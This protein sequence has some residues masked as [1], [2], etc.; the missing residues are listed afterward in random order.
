MPATTEQ[1]RRIEAYRRQV[2]EPLFAALRAH[3]W[4]GNDV[5]RHLGLHRQHIYCIRRGQI[6]MTR[7][8]ADDLCRIAG[9]PRE[10]IADAVL[11]QTIDE[12]AAAAAAAAAT[13]T[14]VTSDTTPAATETTT[15]T[16]TTRRRRGTH[17]QPDHTTTGTI[18]NVSSSDSGTER[19][20]NNRR[21]RVAAT[22]AA[23]GA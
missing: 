14:T 15:A 1:G 7:A 3:G 11:R 20:H 19:P 6:R 8:Q 16:T 18:G 13:E 12:Y 4:N 17:G 5:G 9:Y 22:A 2:I 21:R 10:R 23:M